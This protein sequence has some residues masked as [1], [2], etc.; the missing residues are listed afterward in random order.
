M[1]RLLVLVVLALASGPAL[2]QPAAPQKQLAQDHFAKGNI[3]Y[4]LGRFDEAIGEFTKAYEVW[5]QPAFLYNIAQAHR[6]AGR[7]KD[8]LYFYKRFRALRE[9]DEANPL[10]PEKREEIDRFITELTECAARTDAMAARPPDTIEKPAPLS[11]A[12]TRPPARP[13]V[14]IVDPAESAEPDELDDE[15]DESIE[16]STDA[17]RHVISARVGLGIAIL[18][19][20]DADAVQ[21]RL[22][23]AG[24]YP[25]RAADFTIE[26]GGA[27]S[28]TPVPYEA[29]G[30]NERA[31]LLAPRVFAAASHPIARKL[32][33]RGELA[34]GAVAMFGLVAGNPLTRDQLAGWFVMPSARVS[35]AAEYELTPQLFATVSPLGLAYSVGADGMLAD[36]LR[37]LDLSIG[38]AYRR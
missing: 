17:P 1:T 19:A 8:A 23:L 20:G 21:P 31:T 18:H 10:R 27:L 9:R 5:P 33:V 11:P 4:D 26:L 3:A 37:E 2:A 7:C 34:L 13:A 30:A 12:Q 14:A 22:A 6:L 29:A 15:A 35:V 16:T 32:S 25:L 24:A 38:V 36:S 28:F